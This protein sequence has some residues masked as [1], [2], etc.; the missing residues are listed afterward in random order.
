MPAGGA[1]N[2]DGTPNFPVA[3]GVGTSK[4]PTLWNLPT[5]VPSGQTLWF[6]TGHTTDSNYDPTTQSRD[7]SSFGSHTSGSSQVLKTPAQIMAQFA[8]ESQNDPQAFLALQHLLA[9]GPW[10]SGTVYPT[11]AWDR[12]TEA[13]L[14]GAM[15]LYYQLS[16]TGVAMSFTDYL[17]STAA[18]A[19]SLG[20]LG[21]S[22]G[23]S[24]A[25]NT[26]TPVTDP[27]S[28]RAAAQSAFQAA[29]GKGATE[30]QLNHFVSHF[31]AAQITAETAMSGTP[32]APSLTDQAMSYAQTADP[33]AY[34][35]NQRQAFTD[36]L[37]NMFAPPASQ[38]PNMTPVPTV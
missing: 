16:Q 22:L 19:Q 12:N 3:V 8:A 23:G 18:R 31:Q 13:A 24:A 5:D 26:S 36:Q 4:T 30:A 32:A 2:P 6:D 14:S 21:T 11:G 1:T 7:R 15:S 10:G 9:S 35:G 17:Q 29:T 25:K 20:G 37:V 34:K 33:S 28:I 27:A 38:R